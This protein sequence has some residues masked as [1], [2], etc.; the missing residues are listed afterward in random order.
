V[1]ARR[2]RALFPH[3][4][5]R[6]GDDI[7]TCA[8]PEVRQIEVVEDE[9]GEPRDRIAVRDSAASEP[10]LDISHNGSIVF[11]RSVDHRIGDIGMTRR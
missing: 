4:P 6:G 11:Y 5:S 9:S 3:T 7:H 1:I 2:V 10:A 8:N